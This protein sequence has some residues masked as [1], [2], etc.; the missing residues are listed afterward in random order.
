[1]DN[2]TQGEA[3]PT[4]SEGASSAT[5]NI[6][7]QLQLFDKQDGTDG[8]G[9]ATTPVNYHP[10]HKQGPNVWDVVE[11]CASSNSIESYSTS[12]CTKRRLEYNVSMRSSRAKEKRRRL[13]ANSTAYNYESPNLELLRVRES[14]KNSWIAMLYKE[15]QT[16]FTLE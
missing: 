1:M 3:E 13:C 7:N 15:P 14:F 2:W 9:D 4:M 11:P 5:C 16:T 12:S 6:L 8:L 10:K